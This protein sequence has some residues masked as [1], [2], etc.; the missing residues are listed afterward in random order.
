M[1]EIKESLNIFQREMAE[2][3]KKIRQNEVEIN[4]KCLLK[5][6]LNKPN[7]PILSGLYRGGFQTSQGQMQPADK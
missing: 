3:K 7:I 1:R 5:I 6:Q 4:G 2:E